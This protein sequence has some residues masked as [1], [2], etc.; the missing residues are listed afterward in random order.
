MKL[1]PHK[2]FASLLLIHSQA[3]FAES[4]KFN[5][6]DKQV[7]LVELYTS[8]GCSSCPPADRWLSKLKNQAGLW[9]EFV[10][11]AFHVD[12]WDFLGWKD[13][14]SK[15]EYSNRHRLHHVQGHV[16]VVYTPGFF[17]NGREWRGVLNQ[18][19]PSADAMAIGK[20]YAHLQQK[21][22]T[23]KFDST[24]E[25]KNARLNVAILGFDYKTPIKSGENSNRSLDEYFVVIQQLSATS[26]NNSAAT[27][28]QLEISKPDGPPAKRY[29][30]AIWV[31]ENKDLTPLQA[32]GGWLPKNYF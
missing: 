30:L 24:T 13:T 3:I 27:T 10:P 12:Y 4:I 11:L 16:K 14:F 1:L 9:D 6:G 31:S 15:K 7:N 19:P 22:L 23:V 25:I 8:Q 21:L 17:R 20:I 5:S 32:T 28:W 18:P 26:P 2:T 29:W